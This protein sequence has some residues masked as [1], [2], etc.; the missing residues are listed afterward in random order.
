VVIRTSGEWT[1]DPARFCSRS[2][3][4]PFAGWHLHARPIMLF[5]RGVP[6]RL[7]AD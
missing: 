1:V 4:T 3:N 7:S 6:L 5:A 2:R